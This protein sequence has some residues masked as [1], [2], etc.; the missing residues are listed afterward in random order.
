VISN[1]AVTNLAVTNITSSSATIR[2]NTNFNASTL[3]NYGTTTAYGSTA[4]GAANVTT[5]SVT[6]TGLS[7]NTLYDFQVSSTATGNTATQTGSFLTSPQTAPQ[8][9][10]SGYKFTRSGSDLFVDITLANT[11]TATAQNITITTATLGS[12]TS[13]GLPVAFSNITAGGTY[14]LVHALHFNSADF[15]S[16]TRTALS[17]SGTYTGGS[18]SAAERVSVP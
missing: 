17:F 18:F 9:V 11:G 12:K 16:G 4:T 2:W 3:V 6:L 15:P 8:I 1:L 10:V 14:T 13:S 7:P 5:H